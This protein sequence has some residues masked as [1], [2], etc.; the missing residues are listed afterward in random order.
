MGLKEE[1]Q[2]VAVHSAQTRRFLLVLTVQMQAPWHQASLSS[3]RS[4]SERWRYHRDG[5]V[6]SSFRVLDHYWCR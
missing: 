3:R 1:Y 2:K 4:R 6:E 5:L